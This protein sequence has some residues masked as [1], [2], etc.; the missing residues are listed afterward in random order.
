MTAIYDT[1]YP[2]LKY[3]LTQKEIIRV[4]TPVDEELIWLKKRRFRGELSLA[5][6]VYLKCFQR[7]GYFPKPGDIPVSVI[8]YVASFTRF[9]KENYQRLPPVPKATQ[10]R[11]KDAVRRYCTVTAFTLR[12]QGEWLKEFA[13][14][15]A[16]TKEN[17]VDII[18]AMLE[19]LVKESIELPAFSTLERIAYSARARANTT[20][21]RTITQLLNPATNTTLEALLS[22]KTESG[23]TYWQV[24]KSEPKKPS[25]NGLKEFTAHTA[26][27]K[28]LYEKVGPL[29]EI[30]EEKRAQFIH[31]AR[32]YTADRMKAMQSTKRKALL[33]LLVNEQLYCCT[34][35][36]IDFFIREVRKIHNNA[37][38]DLKKFQESS[39]QEQE[40]LIC[41]LRDVSMEVAAQTTPAEAIANITNVL[42]DDPIEVASRCDRLV[43]H[44]FNNYIQFLPRRYTRPLRKALLDCLDLLEIDHTA[45]GGNLLRCLNTVAKFRNEKI[46]SLA[47]SAIDYENS[48]EAPLAIDWIKEQWNTVL[49]TDQKPNRVNRFMHHGM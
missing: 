48:V 29:P 36:L 34:D 25:V 49:F 21:F 20:Y 27:V 14:E 31:E 4:Y 12:N 7:L 45:H 33:A 46:K 5:C 40:N 11:M 15:I 32:A 22:T 1:A 10:K 35:F 39:T 38:S 37:R 47:V 18:N 30:P 6:L 13:N 8:N 23:I 9:H 28:E 16:R 24:L 44:G 26:W 17:L 42:E 19:I 41:M 3:N 2:R 43:L